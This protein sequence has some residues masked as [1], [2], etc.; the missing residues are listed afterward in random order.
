MKGENKIELHDHF[1]HHP[2]M[3]S[4]VWAP[5]ALRWVPIP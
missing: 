3:T 1:Y 4:R 5:M 2:T